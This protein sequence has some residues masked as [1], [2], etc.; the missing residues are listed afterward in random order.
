MISD[1]AITSSGK[2]TSNVLLGNMSCFANEF[3]EAGFV[4]VLLTKCE[5]RVQSSSL[6]PPLDILPGELPPSLPPLRDIQHQI[7]L[8]PG[9]TLPN[10]PNYRMSL[11]EHEELRRKMEELIAKGH[12]RESLSICEFQHC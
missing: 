5:T 9:A 8:V 12:V 1:K 3:Q 7:D 10:H 11:H 2:L 6:V 4:V